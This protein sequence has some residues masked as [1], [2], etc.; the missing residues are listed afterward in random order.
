ML[1][2]KGH[3]VRLATIE[4]EALYGAEVAERGE[5]H[6]KKNPGGAQL[7]YSLAMP[8]PYGMIHDAT[9]EHLP[10]CLLYVGPYERSRE[11]VELDKPGRAYF[12]RGYR[13]TRATVDVPTGP[14]RQVAEASRIL[15]VRDR[16]RFA[17]DQSYVHRFSRPVP[18]LRCGRFHCL[19]LDQGEA[20]DLSW[21]GI[22]R[23]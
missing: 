5:Y 6:P 14:W 7:H 18:V 23:P 19:E 1:L 16:G 21:R 12:G 2:V 3:D 10:K 22:E 4:D 8:P 11:P 17:A 20:C 15:Y 9:G 13:A